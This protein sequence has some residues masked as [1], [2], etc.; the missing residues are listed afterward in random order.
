MWNRDQHLN[1]LQ[2]FHR[3]KR[4]INQGDN[5][6]IQPFNSLTQQQDKEVKPF[7]TSGLR[8]VILGAN[9]SHLP[10]SYRPCNRC[11]R[12]RRPWCRYHVLHSG[13]RCTGLPERRTRC[14]S[15]RCS[16]GSV[17][18]SI[19]H[20][21]CTARDRQLENTHTRTHKWEDGSVKQTRF[22]GRLKPDDFSPSAQPV[23]L[24]IPTHS[25]S[26]IQCLWISWRP[27]SLQ[28]IHRVGL[29]RP[30]QGF[31]IFSPMQT[32]E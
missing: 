31:V 12:Y 15:T 26:V 10:H 24:T 7:P 16:T 30:H 29:A 18:G 2:A 6:E 20:Y 3:I 19:G 21:H 1:I 14:L 13:C 25:Q 27:Q 17:H 28:I 23:A 5:W 11:C 22:K 4:L 9:H 8:C 32:K